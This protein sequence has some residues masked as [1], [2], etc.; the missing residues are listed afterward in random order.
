ANGNYYPQLDAYADVKVTAPILFI[1]KSAS[2]SK[3]DPGDTIVYTI[4]YKN[5]GT[6]WA[7]LVEIVDTIPADTTLVNSTPGYNSS[8]GDKYTWTIGD[9][10]PNSTFTITIIVTVDVPTADGK[11]LHNVVTLDGADANGNY[12]PQL[13]DY[14]DVTVTA[15]ILSI[16][17]T[18]DKTTVNPGDTIT[19]TIQYVNSG[20]GWATLVEIVDTIPPDTTLINAS[21]GYDNSSGDKYTWIIGN[22]GPGA[23]G[24]ITIIV[25]VDVPTSDT[26]LLH[27]EVTLDWADANG[28]YYPQLDAYADVT[29]TAPILSIH[30]DADVSY[31]NPG[32]TIVYT[33]VYNNTGTGWAS[34]VEIIDTIPADTN[35]VSA[36]SGYNMSGDNLTWTIGDLAPNGSWVITITVTVDVPTPDG[37]TLH[38]VVT[39]DWADANGNYYPQLSDYADVVVTAPILSFSKSTPESTADP[40]DTLVYTLEYKNKGTGL[41]TGVKIQDT[42][43]GNVTFVNAS[44]LPDSV[45]SGVYTWNI[46]DLGPNAS[47]VITVIVTVDVPTPD[48]TLLHNGATLDYADANGNSYPQMDDY[49]NVYVTAP[50]LS[51]NK[52]ANVP[53]ADPGDT[54]IF[55]IVITNS[56]TGWASLVEIVDTIPAD[57][58][59]VN[60]TPGYNASSGDEYTWTIGALAPNSSLT[61]TIA[62]TVDFPTPDQTLLHNEATLDWADANGNY[63]PQLSDDA[64]VVVTA[65]QMSMSKT[66]NVTHAYPGAT[67]MYT[68]T[69]TNF[70]TG[71]AYNVVIEDTIPIDTT[72]KDSDPNH[73]SENNKT[74]TWEI[75]IVPPGTTS[76]IHI[77]VTVIMG[78]PDKT[79]L[80]NLAILDYT[81]SNENQYPQLVDY[82]NVTVTAPIMVLDKTADKTTVNPG[83]LIVFTITYMNL[84]TGWEFDFYINDTLPAFTSFVDADPWYTEVNNRTY[85]WFLGDVAPGT[86]EYIYLT[87]MVDAYTPDQEVILNEIGNVSSK[88]TVTAPIMSINKTADQPT[89]DPGDLI[90]YTITIVNIG[91]GNASGVYVND[92]IPNC[93]TYVSSSINYSSNMGNLYVFYFDLILANSTLTFTIIVMVDVG[94]PDKTLLRNEVT[95]DYADVNGNYYPQGYDFADVVVTAPIMFVSKAANIT[96]GTP[97]DAIAYTIYYVNNGTGDASSVTVVDILP[98]DVIYISASSLPDSVSGNILTWVIDDVPSGGT[99]TIIVVV[100]IKPGTWDETVLTNVV[101]LDYSDANDNWIEQVTDSVDVVVT[102]PVMTISKEAGE[103]KESAYITTDITLRV[104]GEKWHDVI[105]TLYNNNVS[106]AVASVYRVPGDPDE[107][108]VTIHNVTIDLLSDSFSAMV[109]YTPFDDFVNGQFWGADPAW[110]IL[111]TEY[112]NEVRIHHTFNIRHQD[113]WIWII[114][115]FRPYLTKLPLTL[116]Y[117]VSYTMFYENIGTGDATNVWVYDTLPASTFLVNSTPVHDSYIGN[118]VGWNIGYVP[119][120]GSGYIFLNISFVF[121]NVIVKNWY[122]MGKILENT[123]T[124]DYSDT[125]G[126]FVEQVSDSAEVVVY[127][128]SELKKPKTTGFSSAFQ[129]IAS[130]A[131]S[132]LMTFLD[133]ESAVMHETYLV[134]FSESNFENDLVPTSEMGIGDELNMNEFNILH[135]YLSQDGYET[136]PPMEPPA[137][138]LVAPDVDTI[139]VI[140][141]EMPIDDVVFISIEEMP[142]ILVIEH[143]IGIQEIT[144]IVLVEPSFTVGEPVYLEEA[145]ILEGTSEVSLSEVAFDEQECIVTPDIQGK[146]EQPETQKVILVTEPEERTESQKIEKSDEEMIIEMES[147]S[148]CLAGNQNSACT[149]ISE[150]P[151]QEA[152]VPYYMGLFALFFAIIALGVGIYYWHLIR[153]KR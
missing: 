128:P 11:T 46:G 83:D 136:T 54:I 5:L 71:Y 44:P 45:S 75:G 99:G 134:F 51:I 42:I 4:I 43:P 111:N 146:V 94:A 79:H 126:N 27:N 32:D 58:T 84:G 120:G 151:H 108:A 102:A 8:S 144:D 23:S 105:L 88:V 20:T 6:G 142:D 139:E 150:D 26:T 92:T 113:T 3:A 89:A 40:G 63:Y 62:V 24:T 52:T 87:V 13:D 1:S 86:V 36:T 153:K 72:F 133:G 35:F 33:I 2:V 78:T 96:E 49:A 14:A 30:K 119:S 97:G 100:K 141:I 124:M 77:N 10:A 47:G 91:T 81:D 60:A 93:T 39:L 147:T 17:K 41:A 69:Y 34:L 56:G 121:E 115:D 106:I 110:L 68:I 148:V 18:A 129:G 95:L 131:P 90:V 132:E 82:A 61:I 130:E 55:T 28:N 103:V 80:E 109:V 145:H 38:N 7:T 59:F 135:V 29:V 64:Y 149:E 19:Y 12:Y 21:P 118:V 101:T 85:H 122:P 116:N 65:P 152:V 112:G 67:I 76:Y 73:T 140:Q 104:A 114:D 16:N 25:T 125:N 70:G 123:A 9:L 50:V 138:E 57:T 22:L 15:P 127:V 117:T 37:T 107:Q 143:G 48:K 137:E 98:L 53:T 31:A 66:A 74:Y